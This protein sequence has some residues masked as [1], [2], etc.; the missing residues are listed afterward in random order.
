MDSK[1][2]RRSGVAAAPLP[3][4]SSS[5]AEDATG[6]A[7]EPVP[8]L[9][10]ALSAKDQV[11]AK[12]LADLTSVLA[13]MEA[14]TSTTSEHVRELCQRVQAGELPSALGVS[15]LEVRWGRLVEW[16]VR[17]MERGERER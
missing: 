2:K 7:P 13:S 9:A 14:D 5:P 17:E 15:F 3:P 6:P 10:H 8:A 16:I 1:G 11:P 12:E 4:P